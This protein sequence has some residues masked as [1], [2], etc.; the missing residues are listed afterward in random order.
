MINCDWCQTIS[1]EEFYMDHYDG[2][3]YRKS[4]LY[5]LEVYAQEYEKSRK[6]YIKELSGLFHFEKVCF[7]Q[8][9]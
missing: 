7:A 9:R 3:M 6:R 1:D 5:N 4:K 2:F 8:R